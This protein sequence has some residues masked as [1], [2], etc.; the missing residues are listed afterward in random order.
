MRPG[1]NLYTLTQYIFLSM[2]R[3]SNP[4]VDASYLLPL[5]LTWTRTTQFQ[6]NPNRTEYSPTTS[7]SGLFG[8]RTRVFYVTGRHPYPWTNRPK[9]SSV[10]SRQPPTGK[11]VVLW[12]WWESNPHP[13]SCKDSAHPVEL[14]PQMVLC[15]I[16]RNWLCVFTEHDM[17]RTS[18]TATENRTPILWMKTI[19]PSR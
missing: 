16:V 18:C 17:L 2:L 7:L 14:Q 6:T 15:Q 8:I 11:P 13:L 5:Y 10:P 1:C 19:G 9:C 3:D 4:W 12:N